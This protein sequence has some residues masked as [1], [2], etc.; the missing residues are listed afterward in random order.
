MTIAIS[1]VPI[2][3][4]KP[5]FYLDINTKAAKLG[6]PGSAD[7]VLL[8]GTQLSTGEATASTLTQL[9]GVDEARTA[10]G[11][12]SPLVYMV[13]AL[14][15]Q[16]PYLSEVWAIGLAEE[17]G[18]AAAAGSILIAVSGLEAGTLTVYVGDRAYRIGVSADDVAADI[19]G[20]IKD[21]LDAD[22]D[23]P[24]TAAVASP[25][26]NITA[27]CK[28]TAGNDWVLYTEYTGSGLTATLTQ[29][30]AGATDPDV[31]DALDVALPEDYDVYVLEYNDQTNLGVVKTH[32]NL[33]A[34]PMEQRPAVA[35][36]G[37][38][39][40]FSAWTTLTA[41][42]NSGRIGVPSFRGSRSHPMLLA[43]ACAAELA[44]ESDRAIPLNNREL[45]YIV[46][47]DDPAD[48]FTRTE[49]ESALSNGGWPIEVGVANSSR[50]VRSVTTYVQDDQ[51]SDDD[52]LLDIQTIRVLDYCRY[53]IRFKMQ[54][55]FSG[56]KLTDE[57]KTANTTDPTQILQ[58]IKGWLLQLQDELGYLENVE[59]WM[60]RLVVERDASVATRVNARIPADIVDGLH[61]FAAELQLIL[62]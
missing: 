60:D 45:T 27:K 8:I 56:V 9:F 19:C 42:I 31:Q 52:T 40:T 59:E 49:Q 13:D 3:T 26:V 38:K 14:L 7:K 36:A 43:A 16:S 30:T 51:G 61:V 5:G 41:A 25:S 29:P 15:K 20:A 12:G 39:G 50:I 62:G 1:S 35:L 48:K 37:F 22:D 6:L 57:A 28:G 17:G 4:R 53:A 46:P 18:A 11:S 44:A 32:L 47:P 24:F 34:G 21:A 23:C 58:S 55:E 54:Q 10:Y 33:A 2:S